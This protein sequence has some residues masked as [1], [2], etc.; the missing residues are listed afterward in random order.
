[1]S[2]TLNQEL[3]IRNLVKEKVRDIHQLLHD[4]KSV[5]SDRQLEIARRELNQYQELLYQN[6]LNQQ[7]EMR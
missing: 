7:M 3:L 1:M 4:K 5:L 2:Y 6:R